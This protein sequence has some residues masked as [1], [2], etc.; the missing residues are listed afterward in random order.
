MQEI[1]AKLDLIFQKPSGE[2]FPVTVEIGRPY[3]VNDGEKGNYAACP[4]AT[5]GFFGRHPD[6]HGEDTFQA[7]LLALGLVQRL[8]T[9]FLRKGGKIYFADEDSEFDPNLYFDIFKI[10]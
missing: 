8:M 10:S 6:I 7:L 9:D 4:V 1:I 5:L 3:E 2:R